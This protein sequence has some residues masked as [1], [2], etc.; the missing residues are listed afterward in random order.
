MDESLSSQFETMSHIFNH[1]VLGMFLNKNKDLPMYLLHFSFF[2]Y[3]LKKID[4]FSLFTSSSLSTHLC[5]S[6]KLR[7]TTCTLSFVIL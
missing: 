5:L 4:S 2:F 7:Q 6:L 3:N 1:V